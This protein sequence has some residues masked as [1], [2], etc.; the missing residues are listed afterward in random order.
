M[1]HF[2]QILPSTPRA[3]LFGASRA[4]PGVAVREL[5]APWSRVL[6][7]GLTRLRRSRG[8]PQHTACV[9]IGGTSGVWPIGSLPSAP[10]PSI[11]GGLRAP[12]RDTSFDVGARVGYVLPITGPIGFWPTAGM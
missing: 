10:T 12:C 8:P 3:P 4:P 2:R 1:A 9:R 11:S 6:G 5:T 7:G